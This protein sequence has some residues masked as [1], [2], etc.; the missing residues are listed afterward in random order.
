MVSNHINQE[1]RTSGKTGPFDGESHSVFKGKRVD[2]RRSTLT[3][4]P[5][6]PWKQELRRWSSNCARV[7]GPT[8]APHYPLITR[9][10]LHCIRCPNETCRLTQTPL[11]DENGKESGG[12]RDVRVTCS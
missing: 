7:A 5:R 8:S 11:A 1:E 6:I 10:S 2:V 9:G 3:H 12:R 4:D